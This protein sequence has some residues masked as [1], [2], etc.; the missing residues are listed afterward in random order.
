MLYIHAK[1]YL[2]GKEISSN[3]CMTNLKKNTL[4]LHTYINCMVEKVTDK[5]FKIIVQISN[6]MKLF[7]QVPTVPLVREMFFFY[8]KTL[9]CQMYV[10]ENS[11]S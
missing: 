8:R 2:L 5:I 7:F 9:N 6:T 3:I 1:T 10:T 4:I 11:H